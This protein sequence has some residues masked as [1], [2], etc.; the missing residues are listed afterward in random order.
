MIYG[1]HISRADTGTKEVTIYN[2]YMDLDA[3]WCSTYA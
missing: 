3:K 2:N 1:K